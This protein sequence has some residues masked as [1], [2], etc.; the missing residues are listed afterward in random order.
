MHVY[1]GYT[2]DSV[3]IVDEYISDI[4]Y[5]SSIYTHLYTLLGY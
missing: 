5:L 3:D 4:I 1:R 2:E